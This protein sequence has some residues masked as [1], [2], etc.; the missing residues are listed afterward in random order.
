[1]V[2]LQMLMRIMKISGGS[3]ALTAWPANCATAGPHQSQP[4]HQHSHRR[5]DDD[6][7]SERYLRE[8]F[9][10]FWLSQSLTCSSLLLENF[11]PSRQQTNNTRS[12]FTPLRENQP[13]GPK[14]NIVHFCGE[15]I[16]NNKFTLFR[17]KLH[18]SKVLMPCLG[19]CPLSFTCEAASK[20]EGFSTKKHQMSKDQKL[21]RV[22]SST[23]QE[24]R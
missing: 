20:L 15:K 2:L 14:Q 17:T 1:M 8:W 18:F 10:W 19:H 5:H 22:I 3:S 7:K 9:C 23:D 6:G 24:F 16:F 4:R 12:K 13:A 21:P 11:L